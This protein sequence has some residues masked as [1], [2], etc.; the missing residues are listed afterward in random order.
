MEKTPT[1]KCM[2]KVINRSIRKSV[3]NMFKINNKD[4]KTTSVTLFWYLY[5][6]L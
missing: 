6:Q 5:C 1:N 3:W 4:I 2:L